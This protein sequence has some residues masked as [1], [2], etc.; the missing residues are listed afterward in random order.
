MCSGY[1]E[2]KEGS[3]KSSRVLR[4]CIIGVTHHDGL[5]V[6]GS[7]LYVGRKNN[8]V[9]ILPSGLGKV[10]VGLTGVSTL[11]RAVSTRLSSI[12]QVV[13]TIV[14][15]VSG[16]LAVGADCSGHAIDLRTY[17]ND[18]SASLISGAVRWIAVGT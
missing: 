12:T 13:A 9:P 6:T 11:A 2:S 3:R 1:K 14:T 5:S 18:G 10:D 15:C 7:G 16:R 4:R 8:E 17:G